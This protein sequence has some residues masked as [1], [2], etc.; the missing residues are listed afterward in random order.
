MIAKRPVEGTSFLLDDISFESYE[1]L[2]DALGER[3]IPHTY[4][5]GVLEFMTL[6]HEHEWLKKV[7]GR[8]IETAS[9]ALRVRIKSSGSMTLR[10]QLKRRGL[11]PDESYYVA[12][13]QLVR[14]RRR[15]DLR[16]DPPP[17]LAVEVDV[18]HKVLDRLEAYS[19]LGVAEVWRYDKSGL[20]FYRLLPSGD[21]RS[22]KTSVAFP[23]LTSADLN[24]FLGRLED[25]DENAM[26][27]EF[28]EWLKKLTAD[29]S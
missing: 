24:R 18:T 14:H 6:T 2:L 17:D 9:L 5:D 26:I 28:S 4:A 7:L 13:E 21:Y 29:K 8:L 19:K 11:E 27:W 3:H 15:L 1:K 25:T 12:N 20:R 10:R 23:Q 16:K 22:S